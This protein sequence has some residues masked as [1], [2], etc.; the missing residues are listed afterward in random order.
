MLLCSQIY[1]RGPILEAVHQNSLFSDMKH[2]VDMP[3]RESPGIYAA[4]FTNNHNF[5]LL[6]E[7][8]LQMFEERFHNQNYPM[9]RTTLR[10]FIEEYFMEPGTAS[11]LHNLWKELCRKISPEVKNS[12]RFSLIYL[13]HPFIIP[14]GRFREIYYWDTYWII[15]GLLRSGMKTTVRQMIE[16]YFALLDEYGLIPNGG[17]K[18]YALRSHPPFLTMMVNE[19]YLA[20]KNLSFLELSLPYLEKEMNE[21]WLAKRSVNVEKD[22]RIYT[23]FHYKGETNTPR[24]ESYRK[25]W[26]DATSLPEEDKANLY[27]NIAAAAE[28][29]WDFS[30]RWLSDQH[31]I[32]LHKTRLVAPVDLNSFICG[33]LKI[34]S[35]LFRFAGNA[36][37]SEIY[38]KHHETCKNTM[39]EVFYD[40]DDGVWYDY[41]LDTK[42]NNKNFYPSNLSPLFTECYDFDETEKPVAMRK[43][44]HYLKN[45]KALEYIDGVPT[46]FIDSSQQWD[47]PNAWAPLVHMMVEGLYKTGDRL[48]SIVADRMTQHWIRHNYDIYKSTNFMFEKVNEY[49]SATKSQGSGGEYEVQT[50]FGWTNGVVI[51]FLVKYSHLLNSTDTLKHDRVFRD[52]EQFF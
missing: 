6:T 4:F 18:Y 12:D 41:Q 5:N 49:N 35:N 39:K 43:I 40:R 13:P 20:T 10:Y 8:I 27:S 22:G 33:N 45:E 32:R 19:Y 29:G 51:E 1:C 14:G 15:L 38:R 25:D 28:S 16:N 11:E 23:I 37:K 9:N 2:F 47:W 7:E 34:M 31:T 17:R 36:Q 21:F 44:L 24:P 46:S 48:L 30:S 52:I 42:K 3:L 26:E 50:G